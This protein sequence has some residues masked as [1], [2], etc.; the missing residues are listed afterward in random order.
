MVSVWAQFSIKNLDL[1]MHKKQE[2]A[3]L[4]PFP[5]SS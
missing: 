5:M 2:A 4:S 1:A 3:S